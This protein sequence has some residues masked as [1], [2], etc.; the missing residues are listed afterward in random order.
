[1]VVP[2]RHWPTGVP[3]G[4]PTP[5]SGASSTS[6]SQSLSSPSQTSSPTVVEPAL[7]IVPVPTEL[8]TLTPVLRQAP[9]TPLSQAAP[10]SK[11]SSMVP[12]QLLSLPSHTS[13]VGVMAFT[14]FTAPVAASHTRWPGLHS[15]TQVKVLPLAVQ[16]AM[17]TG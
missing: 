2:W 1:M 7:Q 13:A 3:Q 17:P 14:Q 8:H 6:P 5:G 11:P 10:T 4:T 12:L 16:P 15:P 9:A